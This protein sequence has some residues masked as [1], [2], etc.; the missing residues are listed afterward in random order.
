MQTEHR[1]IDSSL[2]TILAISIPLILT[3]LSSNL[4]FLID[5]MVLAYYSINAMN[6]AAI[7]GNLVSIFA[8]A[9]IA[10]A[11]ISEIYIGQS[12]GQK[13]FDKLAVPVW[14]M[15]YFSLAGFAIMFPIGYFTEYINLL[16]EYCKK[17]GIEYQRV[18]AYFCSIPAM[19]VAFAAFFI[20]QGKTKIITY[21][22]IIGSVSNVFL[23]ILLIFG[24]KNII[25]EMG[26]SGAAIAT[27]LSELIQILILAIVFF[28]SNNRLRYGTFKNRKFNK[29]IFL[30]CLKLGHPL[31]IGRIFELLAW[32]LVYVAISHVSKN[33]ATLQGVCV[34]IYVLFAFICEGINKSSAAISSNL[35]GQRN[36]EAIRK[37]YKTF[38][39]FILIL[40]GFITIPLILFPQSI[41]YFFD[42]LHEDIS[43]LYPSMKIIFKLLVINITLE[44]IWSALWG[45]LM[46]GGD[47]RYPMIAN[48]CSLWFFVVIPVGIMYYTGQLNSAIPIY[49]L[50]LLWCISTLILL[51]KRYK[52]LK[53]YNLLKANNN[54]T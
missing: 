15:I 38:L 16:P 17:E 51:Y 33:Q 36:L 10:I 8:F 50:T 35:I 19:N 3:A 34:S 1:N 11:G 12:N 37:S 44:A 27:V 13:D 41:F 31:V 54:P 28:N 40:C 18:L 46:S 21:A 6:A 7:C 49:W 39:K 2:K 23:D 48:I 5:R 22:V 24:Y 30:G 52:S 25:P 29:K 32:Y 4:M 26:C 47:T 20:G 53:W 45:I 14:Q 42:M 43:G 9:F